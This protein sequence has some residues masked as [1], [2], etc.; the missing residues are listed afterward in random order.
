MVL[1][2]PQILKV[3]QRRKLSSGKPLD[4]LASPA[5]VDGYL[6]LGAAQPIK[7]AHKMLNLSQ[8]IVKGKSSAI[9][10]S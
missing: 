5:E 1:M 6:D 9:G 10:F 2:F 4:V 7:I 8:D 3:Y